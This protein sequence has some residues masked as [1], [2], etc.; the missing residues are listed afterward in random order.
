MKRQENF[1]T[2]FA[3]INGL[4]R[5]EKLQKADQSAEG[6]RWHI[7]AATK[8]APQIPEQNAWLC[9]NGRWSNWLRAYGLDV[10]LGLFSIFFG[11]KTK[12][13][14][15]KMLF[16][17]QPTC[18]PSA[19]AVW[20]LCIKF[21]SLR[22]SPALI[23]R[24]RYKQGVRHP[25]NPKNSAFLHSLGQKRTLMAELRVLCGSLLKCTLRT[26]PQYEKREGPYLK[27]CLWPKILPA[28]ACGYRG[29]S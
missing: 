26:L 27:S 11:I 29:S 14:R 5:V 4:L 22:G 15:P 23:P 8:V 18:L 7:A 17:W 12:T 21:C 24:S 28:K 9:A 2:T 1:D 25:L 16:W 10:P 3:R 20:K 19:Q 13:K 6:I